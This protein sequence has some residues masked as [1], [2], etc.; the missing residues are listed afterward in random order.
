MPNG[1]TDALERRYRRLLRW[2]PP[3]HRAVHGEEMVGVLLVAARPGQRTPDV[4]LAANLIACGLAIRARRAVAWLTDAQDSM[5]VISLVAPVLM[6]VYA[7]LVLGIQVESV[8]SWQPLVIPFLGGPAAA[9][10]GWLI[11]VV[12]GLTGRRRAAAAITLALLALTLAETLTQAL[13]LTGALSGGL[14]VFFW[15]AGEALPV[16]MTSLAA[17]SLA[18]SAGPRRGLVIL[19]RRRVFPVLASFS[20]AFGLPPIMVLA[21]PSWQ[22]TPANLAIGLSDLL[23]IAV[24]VAITRPRATVDRRFLVLLAPGLL[25]N[26]VGFFMSAAGPVMTTEQMIIVLELALALIVWPIAIVSWR[27]RASRAAVR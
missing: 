6:F 4:T 21:A 16:V 20:V 11:V 13:Q 10:I 18:F 5:A 1:G 22:S 27:G 26:V 14:P 7:T 3:S 17:C 2:Y 15:V 19:G 8:V 9:M 25:I 24:A 23:A 12:L